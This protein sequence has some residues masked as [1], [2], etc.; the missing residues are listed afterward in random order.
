MFSVVRYA[1]GREIECGS[2]E[3]SQ[4]RGRRGSRAIDIHPATEGRH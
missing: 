4:G 3:E 1:K 2:A